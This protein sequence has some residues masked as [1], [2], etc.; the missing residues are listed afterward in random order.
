MNEQDTIN[1]HKVD[2]QNTL[3]YLATAKNN[4]NK[5]EKDWVDFIKARKEHCEAFIDS[6][7]IRESEFEHFK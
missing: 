7:E 1:Q 3:K 5:S 2:A 4:T 6:L